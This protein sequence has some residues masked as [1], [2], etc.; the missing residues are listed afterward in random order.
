MLEVIEQ[1]MKIA[2]GSHPLARQTELR[3]LAW[4]EAAQPSILATATGLLGGVDQTKA[5]RMLQP[6]LLS[7]NAELRSQAAVL[8]RQNAQAD[9]KAMMA[10][11][12]LGDLVPFDGRP[13]DTANKPAVPP[14]N[15]RWPNGMVEAHVSNAGAVNYSQ[16]RLRTLANRYGREPVELSLMSERLMITNSAGRT[17]SS[18]SFPEGLQELNDGMLRAQVDGGLVFVETVRELVAFDMYRAEDNAMD[19]VLWRYSLSRVPTNP[20]KQHTPAQPVSTMNALGIRSYSRGQD[21]EA[22]V[23]PVT[24]AGVVIQKESEIILLD[25]LTGLPLWSRG[26]YDAS[27]TLLS[28]G[29][30]VAVVSDTRN[31]IDILDCRDGSLLRQLELAEPWKPLFA[32][33]KHLAQYKEKVS[34]RRGAIQLET[35][36]SC[37]V[38]LVDA[39]T[40]KVVVEAS[41]APNTRAES[42]ADRY[43]VAMEESGRMWYCNVAT[44]EVVEHKLDKQPKLQHVRV[45]QFGE[46]LVVWTSIQNIPR[47]DNLMVKPDADEPTINRGIYPINGS[48]IALDI[49]N[50]QLLWDRAGALFQFRSITLSRAIR[51]SLASIA[52]S[53][54]AV[55]DRHI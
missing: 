55:L 2:A 8:M 52:S 19:P 38:R 5:E 33:G 42:C 14:I 49:N 32:S 54:A 47:G 6:I 41:F 36:D 45:Q 35:P 16:L 22:I 25:A 17:I 24:P 3:F 7:N 21:R 27:T 46:R 9:D 48:I 15:L 53:E 26:G 30:E 12:G 20:R 34:T 28:H 50:G 23:G 51:L 4:L 43:L 39:F 31:K 29:V 1:R 18:C 11:P 37:D 13:D 44:G 40:A 10:Y